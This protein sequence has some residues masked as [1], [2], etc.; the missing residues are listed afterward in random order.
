[1]LLS[2][3]WPASSMQAGE[4]L[5]SCCVMP[6][7]L[8]HAG[9]G[10]EVVSWDNGG[11]DAGTSIKYSGAQQEDDRQ[12]PT[13]STAEQDFFEETSQDAP[14]PQHTGGKEDSQGS[15]HP[16]NAPAH[17]AQG[18]KIDDTGAVPKQAAGSD[19]CVAP[20]TCAINCTQENQV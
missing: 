13:D 16:A 20:D 6:M 1:M 8:V 10:V 15:Q 2:F 18:D 9:E 5:T 3:G 14:V 12:R 11:G 4:G 7:L 19:V 17:S